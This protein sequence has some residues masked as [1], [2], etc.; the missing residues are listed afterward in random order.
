MPSSRHK[1]KIGKWHP[2]TPDFRFDEP[3]SVD[4]G[5]GERR[6]LHWIEVKHFYGASSIRVDKKSACG[7]IPSKAQTYR[8]NFGPGAYLFSYGCGEGMRKKMPEGVIVL[9]ESVLDIGELL[10]VLRDWC[11]DRN[12]EIWP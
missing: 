10:S 2:G 11:A 3:I 9:D 5:D 12:G 4:V 1:P 8:D 7:K 6:E